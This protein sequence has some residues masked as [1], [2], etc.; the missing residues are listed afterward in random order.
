MDAFIS[1]FPS[2]V[3]FC[4]RQHPHFPFNKIKY[5]VVPPCVY[6]VGAHVCANH[7]PLLSRF[8][9]AQKIQTRKMNTR[10]QRNLNKFRRKRKPGGLNQGGRSEIFGET[11]KPPSLEQKESSLSLCKKSHREWPQAQAGRP[12]LGQPAPPVS[13]PLAPFRVLT[14]CHFY[15][16]LLLGF[17]QF[18][19]N[20]C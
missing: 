15:S 16:L 1:L 6:V 5:Q 8:I 17:V 2:L 9:I 20:L 3:Q 11:T 18:H 7:N 19:S 4:N 13:H 14:V 10:C 12:L